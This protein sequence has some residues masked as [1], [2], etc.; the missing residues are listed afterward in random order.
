[1]FVSYCIGIEG[2]R[3]LAFI[4]LPLTLMI[5]EVMSRRRRR[6]SL[7]I[8]FSPSRE[9]ELRTCYVLSIDEYPGIHARYFVCLKWWWAPN[10]AKLTGVTYV[11]LEYSL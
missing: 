2:A 6:V 11:I 9:K 4:I 10:G 5:N 8:V 7:T 3:S 1:M